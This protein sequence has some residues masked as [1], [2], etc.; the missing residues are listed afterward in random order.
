MAS[1]LLMLEQAR[2]DYARLLRRAL[3]SIDVDPREALIL[4]MAYLNTKVSVA[5]LRERTGMA[6]STISSVVGR[7]ERDGRVTRFRTWP[8]H[9][10]VWIAPTPMGVAVARIVGSGIDD[11][12]GRV[13]D[14]VR[15]DPA[16]LATLALALNDLANPKW[17]PFD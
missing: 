15:D 5:A 12:A 14:L 9:R 8:D 3:E 4:R 1:E 2:N 7:L 11:I 6:A 13:E 16:V 17:R 10:V